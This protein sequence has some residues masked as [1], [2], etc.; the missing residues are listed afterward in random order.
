M[1]DIIIVDYTSLQDIL[2]R[3]GLLIL[4]VGLIWYWRRYVWHTKRDEE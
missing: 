1:G 3:V 2:W 4:C